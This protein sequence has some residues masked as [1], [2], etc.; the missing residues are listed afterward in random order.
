[1]SQLLCLIGFIATLL[2]SSLPAVAQTSSPSNQ[3]GGS[4]KGIVVNESGRP[5]ANVQINLRPVGSLD[6]R[7][8]TSTDREG[9]FEFNG[10]E[11]MV[12][13]L[14]PFLRGYAP[15]MRNDDADPLRHYRAG[16]SVRLVLI[17]GGIITGA[18]TNQAG[19]PVVGVPVRAR[20]VHSSSPMPFPYNFFGPAA[21]T[22][23]RGIYRLYGLPEGTYVVWAGGGGEIHMSIDPFDADVPTYA[24]SS[25][26]DTAAE[27]TVRAG[28]ESN[29]DIR[30][31]GEP[32][33]LVSGRASG[34]QERQPQGFAVLL[35]S[36]SGTGPQWETR[37]GQAPDDR[38]F[39]FLGVDDG[40]YELTA[41]SPPANGELM[42]STPKRIKVRGADVT[43]VE[44][45]VQPL[46]SVS[47]RV[48]LEESTTTECSD[49]RRPR[50]T[51]TV[52][53]AQ[54]N[55]NELLKR[56][57]ELLW[58]LGTTVYPDE[59]GN[60]LL[61]NLP[62]GRYYFDTQFSGKDWYLKSLTFASSETTAAKVTKPTDAARNWTTLKAG[63]RLSG[64]TI[65]LAQGAASL[66]GQIALREG[67]TLP[68]NLYVYLVPAEKEKADDPLRFY[69]AAVTSEG[70]LGLN[71]IAPGRYWVLAQPS[72]DETLSPLTR[73]RLP[74]EAA[75]RAKI[76]RDGE[77]A[78]TETE[79]KPCQKLVDFQVPVKRN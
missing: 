79:L 59:Q 17:K 69:G 37:A 49:K 73:L 9:K 55:E 12:Y 78:K 18:V 10:L 35:T 68:D 46:S 26:P 7:N 72:T 52:V 56:N 74:D 43:G 19:E 29:A 58:L 60:L 27:I 61:K 62:A 77:M 66:R 76:R 36:V 53:S 57:R 39:V 5:L 65:T 44:L 34:P 45:N 64:L 15:L 14:Y 4:I 70:K 8:S 22:D 30:Y 2:I 63:D 51:E 33:H 6:F 21:S 38:G 54:Q 20:M 31:R 11:P 32:G 16:D 71:H 50:F 3:A 47:G 41:I 48:V 24:P 67:E 40:E 75:Y 13:E 25:T 42:L 28:L 1:M 23:D